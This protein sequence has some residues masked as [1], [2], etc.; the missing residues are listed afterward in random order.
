[1]LVLLVYGILSKE[2]KRE[3]FLDQYA[4][5]SGELLDIILVH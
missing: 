3:T 2:E 1:M 5:A 4:E